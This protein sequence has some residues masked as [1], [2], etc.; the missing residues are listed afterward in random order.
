MLFSPF[1]LRIPGHPG[2]YF[3]YEIHHSGVS[4]ATASRPDG[5]KS[6]CR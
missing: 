4:S 3:T 6:T 2:Q 5:H 1:P